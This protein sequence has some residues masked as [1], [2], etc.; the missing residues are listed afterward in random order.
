MKISTRSACSHCVR[1]CYAFSGS[2]F[3]E[4]ILQGSV[5]TRLRCGGICNDS[6]VANFPPRVPAK[7]FCKSDFIWRRYGQEFDALFFDAR[8]T[9][10]S[11]PVL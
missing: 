7:E 11:S 3:G 5:A 10:T 6:F 1:Y 8:C 4:N 2:V 9:A